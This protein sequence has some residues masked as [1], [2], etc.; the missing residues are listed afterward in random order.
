MAFVVLQP[1]NAV[2]DARATLATALVP[3]G[4]KTYSKSVPFLVHQQTTLFLRLA[5]ATSIRLNVAST[6][7]AAVFRIPANT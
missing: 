5:T 7:P 6:I 2:K 1:I 3:N 4:Q